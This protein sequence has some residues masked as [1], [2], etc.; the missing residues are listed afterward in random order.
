MGDSCIL[1]VE[2]HPVS[3]SMLDAMLKRNYRVIEAASGPEALKLA[4]H[5]E[6]DLV[7][8]DVEMPGMD[9][10]QLLDR[11]RQGI[12]ESMNLLGLFPRQ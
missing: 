2:D 8:L 12:I 4:Q 6:P 7:L 11:L 5:E 3:R 10:F 9:G 1:V